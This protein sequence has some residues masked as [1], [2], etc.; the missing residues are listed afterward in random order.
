MEHSIT[1]LKYQLITKL[2]HN[3]IKI[4]LTYYEQ[5]GTFCLNFF[6]DK[7]LWKKLQNL[8]GTKNYF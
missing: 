2:K 1:K 4:V 8:K 7:K 5:H 6:D 3:W